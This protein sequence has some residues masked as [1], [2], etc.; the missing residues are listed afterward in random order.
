MLGYR[1]ARDELVADCPLRAAT[2]LLA[3]RWDPVVLLALGVGARRRV[4]LRADIGGVSDKALTESLRRL[5]RNGLV[6]RAEYPAAPPRVEYAL[7]ALGK[8]LVAGPMRALGDWVTEHGHELL[9]A[10]GDPEE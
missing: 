4:D 6:G 7:T 2:D 8:S 1:R 3:H 10:Q 9:A 5:V